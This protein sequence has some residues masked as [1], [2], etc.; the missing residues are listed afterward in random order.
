[1][2]IT[3]NF[4]NS[5]DRHGSVI[6][7]L[8]NVKIYDI[9]FG[10]KT[11]VFSLSNENGDSIK[12]SI[13]PSETKYTIDELNSFQKRNVVKIEDVKKES[14]FYWAKVITKI[15]EYNIVDYE[16]I[17]QKLTAKMSESLFDIETAIGLPDLDLTTYEESNFEMAC[18][19]VLS[20][21]NN[22]SGPT[23]KKRKIDLSVIK[24]TEIKLISLLTTT[25]SVTGSI[26]SRQTKVVKLQ[27][28][29]YCLSFDL[30]DS[31]E[32]SGNV[33]TV[34]FYSE[35]KD[36]PIFD[37][38]P[39]LGS[40]VEVH[41]CRVIENDVKFASND[42]KFALKGA[43]YYNTVLSVEYNSILKDSEFYDYSEGYDP[44]KYK[45]NI[46]LK[47]IVS[48][49]FFFK[50]LG[51]DKT[52]LRGQVIIAN[53]GSM[54][55]KLVLFNDDI[56]NFQAEART[57]YFVSNLKLVYVESKNEYCL[58]ATKYTTYIVENNSK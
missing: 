20:T 4:Q 34:T 13:D 28:E 58:N 56:D 31:S 25:I 19:G 53:S 1:M 46:N 9:G 8:D 14:D 40:I 43:S 11:A 29:E 24:F 3:K 27:N 10:M 54:K 44:T 7:I 38:V 2:E 51:A 17:N 49:F 16:K 15:D 5:I 41:N 45:F 37:S 57:T 52:L 39:F 21:T 48:N 23:V 30:T 12:I 33:I 47:L 36:D 18:E 50:P 42:S 32:K 35:D 6:G 55:V 26:I 22:V